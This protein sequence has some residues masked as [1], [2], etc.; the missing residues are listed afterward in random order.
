[1][2]PA[3]ALARTTS[4]LVAA[5]VAGALLT[6]GA[7]AAPAQ[8]DKD[9]ARGQV[10]AATA[11]ADIYPA[12]TPLPA[13]TTLTSADGRDRLVMQTD[14]NLVLYTDNRARWQS[15]TS[16]NPG[17]RGAFQT[18][19]NLVIY[20][21]T[22]RVLW[23]SLT[24]NLPDAELLV[25]HGDVLVA[26]VTG[27]GKV[28]QA[29]TGRDRLRPGQTL[30]SGQSITE[31]P[32]FWYGDEAASPLTRLVMQTDGNLVLYSYRNEVLWA[33]GTNNNPGARLIMQTDGNLV[34]YSIANRPL[35][36][37]RTFGA[38]NMA[39]VGGFVREYEGIPV[40]PATDT[41]LVT[42]SADRFLFA[43]PL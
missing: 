3:R 18:D 11:Q 39:T 41:L 34:V 22:N 12:G 6:T 32:L 43:R 35:W 10:S 4:A 36:Q 25:G 2:T 20:S 1:M 30:A 33:A 8:Q 26:N 40:F 42:T 37:S 29:R 19:G 5:A 27:E 28:W 16:G 9:S 24:N 7:S 38:G 13:G 14:G 21:S 17:A 31:N 23:A 15:G